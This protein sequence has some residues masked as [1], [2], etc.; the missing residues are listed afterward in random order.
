[1]GRESTASSSLRSCAAC[2]RLSLARPPPPPPSRPLA[3]RRGR[4]GGAQPRDEHLEERPRDLGVLLDEGAALAVRDAPAA[5]GGPRGGGD[6]A[7]AAA[8]ERDLA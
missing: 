8:D 2:F 3:T 4:L 6:G 7:P 5:Q 1:M